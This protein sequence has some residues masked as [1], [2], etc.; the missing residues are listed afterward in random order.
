MQRLLGVA[1]AHGVNDG[2]A[3]D[4]PDPAQRLARPAEGGTA[5]PDLD[6]GVL[7]HVLTGVP[8]AQGM[9]R[10]AVQGRAVLA[11]EDAQ[12]LL[13][14]GTAFAAGSGEGFGAEVHAVGLRGQ[15][16]GFGAAVAGRAPTAAPGRC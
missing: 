1:G 7:H 16:G 13:D 4:L 14:Q 5:Q 9:G 3:H 8:A 2:V 15:Y 11:V 12:P 10:L 6:Q